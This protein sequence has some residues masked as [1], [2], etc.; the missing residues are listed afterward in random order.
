MNTQTHEPSFAVPPSSLPRAP[1]CVHR[2]DSYNGHE[3][4]PNAA[5]KKGFFRKVK[6]KAKISFEEH[7]ERK[8]QQRGLQQ[9]QMQRLYGP[10]ASTAPF[11]TQQHAYPQASMAPG[12]FPEMM[13]QRRRGGDMGGMALP[14][15]GGFAGGLLMGDMLGNGHD[16]GSDHGGDFG[17]F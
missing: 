16:G 5:E 15:A 4:A 10:G 14:M 9:Q 7:N 2:H 12:M 13:G 11:H 8:R 1:S 3:A 6:D 17:D